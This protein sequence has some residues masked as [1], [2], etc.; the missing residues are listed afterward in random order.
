[1]GARSWVIVG[2]DS[3][4]QV[5]ER[6]LPEGSLSEAEVITM[7]ERLAARHLVDDEVVSASLRK[8]AVGYR[9]DLEIRKNHGGRYGLMTTGNPHYIASIDED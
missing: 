2:Y 9:P 4:K 5:F 8:N 6:R 7:L 3:T 1:M